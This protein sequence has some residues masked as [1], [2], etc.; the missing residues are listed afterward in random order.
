LGDEGS[1]DKIKKM[2]VDGL[3]TKAEYAGARGCQSAVEEMT[4]PDRDE[5][6][7]LGLGIGPQDDYYYKMKA[8]VPN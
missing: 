1:L 7:A 4:S 3:A 2:F 8:V 5:A 6:F